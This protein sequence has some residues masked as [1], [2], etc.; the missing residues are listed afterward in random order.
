[1]WA[2]ARAHRFVQQQRNADTERVLVAR[3]EAVGRELELVTT[4]L[5]EQRAT[6]AM[7]ERMT[8]AHARALNGYREHMGKIGAGS[9]RKTQAF[10]RA[11]RASMRKAQ[12]AVPA[13]VVPLPTLLENLEPM[14]DSFDVV[15]IDEASQIGIEHLYLLWLAPRVIVVGDDKQCTPGLARLGDLDTVFNQNVALMPD[16]EEDIRNHFTQKS[17]LYG[18]LTARAGR[19]AVIRLREHFRCMPEIINW[20]SRTFYPDSSGKP[21]L[22]PLRERRA[23]DLEPLRLVRVEGASEEGRDD[24]RRN[25]VEAKEIVRTLTCCLQDPQYEGKTFGVVVLTGGSGQVRLLDHEINAAI[26]AEERAARQIRVGI[27]SDFQGDERDVIML[28]M[29]VA[30]TPRAISADNFRQSYNVAASR[31]RDQMW[32][33]IS[34]DPAELRPNDL[35]ADLVGYML[36]PPSIYGDSPELADVSADKPQEPFDSLLEQRVFREIRGRGYHVVPQ[37]PVGER[38]LDLVVSGEGGRIAVECDGHAWHTSV[39]DQENDA[40]RDRDLARQGWV[41]VR[42]RES[43]FEFDKERELHQLWDVL[44]AHG[45]EP[46]S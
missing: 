34:I 9:G 25:P 26:S 19:D 14:R 41:T 8:D 27:A 39:A 30:D 16:I 2:W 22:I 42:V 5:V 1:A 7:L 32:L 17:N 33:F 43:E 4:R 23:H 38:R 3:Y 24:R 13:W 46:T 21:G 12:D 31:A 20:S 37:Y 44:A 36:D 35:R 15:I 11:A 18:V 6:L 45:I 29:V 28:S 40:R 10:R